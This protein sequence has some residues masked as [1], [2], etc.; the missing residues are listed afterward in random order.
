MEI[1]KGDMQ[2]C[3][4]EKN[5]SDKAYFDAIER[6]DQDIM[7]TSLTDSI[8][9]ENCVAENRI[10]Y[11]AKIGIMNKLVFYLGVL[12]KKYDMLFAKQD[13]VTKNFKIFRDNMLPDLNQIDELIQQYTF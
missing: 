5:I 6:Y 7:E 4:I 10:Q 2:S 9:Y 13:I 8:G 3:I 1:F 12:Q 11:N